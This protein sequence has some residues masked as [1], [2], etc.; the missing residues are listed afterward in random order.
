MRFQPLHDGRIF[1]VAKGLRRFRIIKLADTQMSPDSPYVRAYVEY[2]DDEE[3]AADLG[4]LETKVC[5]CV[6]M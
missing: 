4:A 6:C 1:M 3:T 5:V 2:I